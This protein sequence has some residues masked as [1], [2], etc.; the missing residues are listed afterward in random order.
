MFACSPFTRHPG[1]YPSV[2]HACDGLGSPKGVLCSLYELR[3]I[4]PF[5]LHSSCPSA[6]VWSGRGLGRRSPHFDTLMESAVVG[7]VL[8]ICSKIPEVPKAQEAD[9]YEV[10]AVGEM[11]L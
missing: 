10:L 2:V 6:A 3:C 5:L 11:G 4:F 9:E 7:K 8:C 1:K